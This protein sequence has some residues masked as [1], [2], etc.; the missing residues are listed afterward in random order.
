MIRKDDNDLKTMEDKAE[1]LVAL[2][3]AVYETRLASASKSL[4]PPQVALSAAAMNVHRTFV[5]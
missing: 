1:E 3:F 4:T 5:R 2:T